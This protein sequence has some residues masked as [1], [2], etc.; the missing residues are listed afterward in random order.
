MQRVCLALLCLVVMSM[1]CKKIYNQFDQSNRSTTNNNTDYKEVEQKSCGTVLSGTL[2][3]ITLAP[4]VYCFDSGAAL[5]GLLT[6]N[7]PASGEWFFKIGTLGP[8]GLTMT[9]FNMVMAGSGN[10]CRVTWQV[11]DAIT[12]TD[13]HIIGSF[14]A[15]EAVTLTRGS[16][17][18]RVWSRIN[19]ITITETIGTNCELAPA[20]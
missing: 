10:A 6:L 11:K 2:A 15:G 3:G 1:G 20:P 8:G 9:D 4:G 16:L 17:L 18:G 13:S 5:T 14:L 19:A 7:G 12:S